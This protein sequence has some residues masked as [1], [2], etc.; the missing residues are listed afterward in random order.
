MGFFALGILARKYRLDRKLIKHFWIIFFAI[1]LFAL[2]FYLFFRFEKNT[3]FHL[4]AIFYEIPA[5]IVFFYLSYLLG[6]CKAFIP[7]T[8]VGKWS[9]TMYMYHMMICQQ[10]CFKLPT[11]VTPYCPFI[12]LGVMCLLIVIPYVICKK[13]RLNFFLDL[14]GLR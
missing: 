6:K 8:F 11:Y 13:M 9:F 10:I 12:S 1:C 5:V 4:Y 7:L 3:Y 14:F 2:G